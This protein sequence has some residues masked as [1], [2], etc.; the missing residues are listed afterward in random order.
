MQGELYHA[1]KVIW[2]QSFTLD[3]ISNTLQDL[4]KRTNI[5]K[6]SPYKSISLKEKK[7][8]RVDIKDKAK[9]RVAGVIKKKNSCNSCGSTD[10]YANNFPKANKK[11]YDIEKFPEEESPTKD[12]ESYSLGEAIREHSYDDQYPK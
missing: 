9:E 12:S 10:H 6:Y 7:P 5:G 3:D 2:N 4:R 11:V 8:S 1:I